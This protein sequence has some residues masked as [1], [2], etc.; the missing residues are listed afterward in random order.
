MF[1]VEKLHKV[2]SK[3]NPSDFFYNLLAKWL[4]EN[5]INKIPFSK[6]FQQYYY[7]LKFQIPMCH[8]QIFKTL[9]QNPEDVKQFCKDEN[10]PFQLACRKWY[11]YF[12]PQF[13]K[14]KSFNNTYSNMNN[15]IIF[16]TLL[17]KL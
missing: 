6:C 7:L 4:F 2:E 10:N 11:L 17:Q 13:Y 9:S 14:Q 15:V 5:I 12:N 8:R 1:S 3:S 16:P